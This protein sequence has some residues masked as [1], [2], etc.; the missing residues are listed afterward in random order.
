MQNIKIDIT[1]IK[2]CVDVKE[3]EETCEG[4]IRAFISYITYPGE[5]NKH[6]GH[7]GKVKLFP[8]LIRKK[9]YNKIK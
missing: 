9:K 3:T 7:L 8:E 5:K 2:H 1:F 6:S 4:R